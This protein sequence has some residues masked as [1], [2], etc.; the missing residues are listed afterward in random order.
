VERERHT[1][2]DQFVRVEQGTLRVLIYSEDRDET[3]LYALE[4]RAGD[5]DATIIPTG[6]W[7]Q[8]L[9]DDV[10]V[11]LFYTIYAPPVH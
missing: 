6:T 11:T 7:H 10:G 1:Y 9:N 2:Q 3:L 4:L 5:T 8:L